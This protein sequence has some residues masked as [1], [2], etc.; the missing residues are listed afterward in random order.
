MNT[1]MNKNEFAKIKD[2]QILISRELN[3][4]IMMN[5]VFL[6]NKVVYL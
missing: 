3:P 4:K 2:K 1:Y 5:N 6:R